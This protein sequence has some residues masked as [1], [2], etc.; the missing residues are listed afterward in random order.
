MSPLIS[1]VAPI[2]NEGAVADRFVAR[3]AEVPTTS[4][5]WSTTTRGPGSPVTRWSTGCG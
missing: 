2:Y 4:W 3:L 1:V 5:S